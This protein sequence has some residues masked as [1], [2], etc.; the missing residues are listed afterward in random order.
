MVG[1]WSVEST[2]MPLAGYSSAL[3][4]R[5][6]SLRSLLWFGIGKLPSNILSKHLVQRKRWQPAEGPAGARLTRWIRSAGCPEYPSEEP[7]WLTPTA[8]HLQPACKIATGIHRNQGF[9]DEGY[10][11]VQGRRIRENRNSYFLFHF[12]GPR[13]NKLKLLNSQ[14]WGEPVIEQCLVQ[15]PWEL[16]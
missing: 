6:Q 11:V 12:W 9:W 13:Q 2:K 7:M 5:C 10:C 15:Q 8:H 16:L 3:K 4:G 1:G 14:W